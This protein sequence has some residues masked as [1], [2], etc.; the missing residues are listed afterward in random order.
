MWGDYSNFLAKQQVIL[1]ATNFGTDISVA[2]AK[3]LEKFELSEW[4]L[5]NVVFDTLK[6]LAWRCS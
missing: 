6:T 3:V 4:Y 1:L 2:F 5:I